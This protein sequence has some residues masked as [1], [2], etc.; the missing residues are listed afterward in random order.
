VIVR[1]GLKALPEVLAELGI[2]RPLLVASERWSSL[3]LPA[4]AT[5]HEIPSHRIE[6]PEDVADVVDAMR[7]AGLLQALASGGLVPARPIERIT[8]LDIR[9]AMRGRAPGR[10]EAE[11]VSVDRALAAVEADAGVRLAG[12]TFRALCDEERTRRQG[13]AADPGEPSDEG[14]TAV[15]A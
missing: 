11:P 5:W 6:A 10:P 13:H 14:P 9:Q 12:T 7:T 1:W 2:E 8:L 4:A 15:Q 3:D